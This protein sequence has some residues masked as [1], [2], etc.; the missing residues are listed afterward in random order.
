MNK[1]W[2]FRKIVEFSFK[3]HQEFFIIFTDYWKFGSKF[4]PKFNSR[5]IP[6]FCAV[7]YLISSAPLLAGHF[8]PPPNSPL[9]IFFSNLHSVRSCCP[10]SV[11]NFLKLKVFLIIETLCVLKKRK[12][13]FRLISILKILS[14]VIENCYLLVLCEKT[15]SKK[16]V[17]L[18]VKEFPKLIAQQ[19]SSWIFH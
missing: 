1:L 11:K 5:Q 3:F 12:W 4:A 7:L 16:T 10:R 9:L 18:S 14:S 2:K 19:D 6:K 15:G 17:I 8:P 13:V